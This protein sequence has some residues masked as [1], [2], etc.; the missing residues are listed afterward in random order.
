MLDAGYPIYP[1]NNSNGPTVAEYNKMSA[2][3]QWEVLQKAQT[4]V[5]EFPMKSS[6]KVGIAQE[7]AISQ[8][9]RY[10][11]FQELWTDHNTSITI[12]FSPDEVDGLV[13]SILENW[14]RYIAISFLPK[15]NSVYP[16]LP[17]EEITEA[18]YQRRVNELPRYLNEQYVT[19]ALIAM[20]QSSGATELLDADCASGACPVR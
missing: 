14:D 4:W 16:L 18:E 13:D 20:E 6:T 12:T 10:L 19:D 15:D 9:R 2:M 8:F 7:T 11:L 17:E 5:I 1:E 3:A